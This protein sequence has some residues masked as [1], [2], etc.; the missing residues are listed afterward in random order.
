MMEYFK[1]SHTLRE[2]IKISCLRVAARTS[3][4]SLAISKNDEIS[5]LLRK[6]EDRRQVW[7]H[8]RPEPPATATLTIFAEALW[9]G[10]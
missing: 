5:I 2:R 1:S 8:I 10:N 9:I 6:V 3:I 4:I 7:G